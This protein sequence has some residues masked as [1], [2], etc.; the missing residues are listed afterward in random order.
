MGSNPN[1]GP[2]APGLEPAKVYTIIAY[3]K[4]SSDYDGDRNPGPVRRLRPVLL[5]AERQGTGALGPAGD[6]REAKGA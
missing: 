2:N 6:S 5:K 3:K 1:V 4:D